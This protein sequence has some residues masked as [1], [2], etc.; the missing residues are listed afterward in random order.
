MVLHMVCDP[1][2]WRETEGVSEQGA[3]ENI[4][5]YDGR[6][7]RKTGKITKRRDL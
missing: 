2:G 5:T 1:K 3:D 6:S 7:N 4:W